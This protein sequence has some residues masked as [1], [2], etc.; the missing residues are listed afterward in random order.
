M[1]YLHL[2]VLTAFCLLNEMAIAQT[3]DTQYDEQQVDVQSKAKSDSLELAAESP[4]TFALWYHIQQKDLVLAQQEFAR[5]KKRHPRWQPD[6]DLLNAI[7]GLT[8]AKMS[9]P[10][11]PQRP[12]VTQKVLS[13]FERMSRGGETHWR[14]MPLKQLQQASERAFQEKDLAHHALLGWAFISREL[15][16]QS[17]RHFTYLREHKEDE[18]STSDG[19]RQAILGLVTQAVSRG[20]KH[21]LVELIAKYP[22]QPIIEHIEFHAWQD[23][24][25]KKYEPALEWFTFTDNYFSQVLSLKQLGQ[26]DEAVALACQHV[27]VANLLT[28][29]VNAYSEKQLTL[30][31]QEAY[32]ASIDIAEKIRSLQPLKT[33][34]LEIFAWS[35]FHLGHAQQSV[36]AFSDLIQQQPD[37]QNY[38]TILVILLK[39]DQ[40]TLAELASTYPLIA[41]ELSN[42]QQTLAWNRKQFNRFSRLD[43]AHVQDQHFF[44]EAGIHWRSQGANDPLSD[45]DGQRYFLGLAHD[46]QQYRFGV[47]LNYQK[48]HSNS[49]NVGDAFGL[50]L[51]NNAYSGLTGTNELG[52]SGFLK[53]QNTDSNLLAEVSYWRPQHS[54]RSVL[55]GKVSGVRFLGNTTLAMAIF[56]E[57]LNDSTL[58][59]HGLFTDELVRWGSVTANGIKGLVAYA[60]SP[61][62][63]VS[64][65][66]A[67]AALRGESVRNNHKWNASLALTRNLNNIYPENLDYLRVG[68]YLSWTHYKKNLNAF[69]V[70]NGGYFSPDLLMSLGG[71]AEV[72]TLED[73]TWQLK[74]K[75]DLGYVIS[76][77]K[78]ITVFLHDEDEQSLTQQDEQGL[79][80]GLELEGQWLFHPKWELVG[81]IKHNYSDTYSEL[82]IGLHIR[83]N[84]SARS[85][86]T[87]DGFI[88]SSPYQA[89]Y[90][91][92]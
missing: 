65:E 91:W 72:L 37:N 23:Y 29:C 69:T 2:T 92:Y 54:L 3:V 42:Q 67:G 48:T 10:K 63:S 28:Y 44:L 18:K 58:S 86:E 53:R 56:R 78:D 31:K 79:G 66:L 33:A 40:Q 27:L 7:S 19:I 38:A 59:L 17:L 84:Y 14:S 47:R 52:I 43:N 89:D 4:D 34:Q 70:G 21:A 73:K 30:F 80:L 68:P 50:G 87:S 24:Q 13:V 88:S 75:L 55:T 64:A 26:E 15:Y 57:R 62:W 71:R 76:K 5:L 61:Q 51:L 36:Q 9:R 12:I 35:H 11:V 82:N 6:K 83:W 41:Q 85:G 49:P 20:D 16:T 60:V 25:H 39:D 74:G 22:Q 81:Q 1:K 32:Q 8:T 90:P 45:F 77:P 46:W